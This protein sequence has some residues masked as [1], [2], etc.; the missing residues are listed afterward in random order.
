MHG[1]INRAIERF[2]RDTYGRDVWALIV[3]RA[4]LGFSEF[5]AMLSRPRRMRRQQST[6]CG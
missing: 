5:E 6:G 4:G 3:A 1:L 2:I